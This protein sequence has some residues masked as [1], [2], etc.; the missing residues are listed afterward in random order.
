MRA[1]SVVT[2]AFAGVLV[3]PAFA[4]GQT[5]LGGPALSDRFGV[6]VGGTGALLDGA[7]SYGAGVTAGSAVFVSAL[8]GRV[9]PSDDLSLGYFVSTPSPLTAVEGGLG[10][11]FE[12]TAPMAASVC[13]TIS[14]EYG[15]GELEDCWYDPIDITMQ[16]GCA[17][18]ELDALAV[19]TTVSVGVP[20][21][22]SRRVTM[23]AGG[24]LGFSYSRAKASAYDRSSIGPLT[25]NADPTTH[26]D[27]S[28]SL[29]LGLALVL[30]QRVSVGPSVLVPF[31]ADDNSAAFG[32]SLALALR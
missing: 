24:G 2:V 8:V 10:Y 7:R 11:E 6:Q 5:C 22:L 18:R 13:P 23:V 16:L 30:A 31:A 25:I 21:Q 17:K 3:L 26:T 1:L 14:V 20:L 28:G 15:S 9:V 29:A 4:S 19:G 27:T 32:M 12:V